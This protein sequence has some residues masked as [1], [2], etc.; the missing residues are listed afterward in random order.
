MLLRAAVI[1]VLA[2][3]ILLLGGAVIV[4]RIQIATVK[5][6]RVTAENAA[7]EMRQQLDT[8]H[9]G[10]AD[11]ERLVRLASHGVGEEKQKREE[12]EQL[13]R[14]LRDQL[15]TLTASNQFSETARKA[16]EAK[17]A[18]PESDKAAHEAALAETRKDL[19]HA[20]Q[21]A[22]AAEKEVDELRQ[23]VLGLSARIAALTP[24]VKVGGAAA[25]G[26]PAAS[27]STGKKAAAATLETGAAAEQRAVLVP[28]AT[29][30]QTDPQ[31][32]AAKSAESEKT[33]V[34]APEVTGALP[35]KAS[36][37]EKP[38]AKPEIRRAP[39]KQAVHVKREPLRRARRATPGTSEGAAASSGSAETFAPF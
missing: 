31:Q 28:S 37:R 22:D 4:Q 25:A 13:A 39:A 35:D 7:T 26:D 32:A 27:S 23:Q 24:A 14:Q 20:R 16:A 29:D 30:P 9:S 2:V 11:L 6:E 18:T 10:K 12:A 3:A 38:V 36:D 21:A 19:E 5:S 34:A 17:M 1:Y 15:D 8:L 33:K